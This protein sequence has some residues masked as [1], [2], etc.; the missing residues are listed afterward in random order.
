MCMTISRSVS[1]GLRGK[2]PFSE[3]GVFRAIGLE[4]VTK[5]HPFDR[6]C[7]RTFIAG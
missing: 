2:R 5:Q 3:V 7:D 6:G 1:R 4:I